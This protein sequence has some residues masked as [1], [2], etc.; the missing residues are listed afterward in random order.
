[1]TKITY[2]AI[3]LA[4][5]CTSATANINESKIKITSATKASQ[6]LQN[7][8]SNVEVI[9]AEQLKS[10]NITSLTEALD[11]VAGIDYTSYGHIGKNTSVNLRGMQSQRT[12][13]LFDGVSLQNPSSTVGASI[14]HVMISDIQR[15]EI[16][17]GAQSGIW[18]ANAAAGVINIITKDSKN[19]FNSNLDLQYGSFNTKKINLS[20]SY[21]T[22]KI[23][24]K[25]VLN[26]ITSDGFTSKAPNG[27]DILKYEDDGYENTSIDY[28]LGFN[29]NDNSKVTLSHKNIDGISQYDKTS[30]DDTNIQ[31]DFNTKLTSI[32]NKTTLNKHTIYTSYSQSKFTR[33]E[34]GTVASAGFTYNGTFYPGSPNVK[35][36]NG[37][38]DSIELKDTYKYNPTSFLNIGVSKED[39]KVNYIN[40][41]DIKNDDK[42]TSNAIFLTNNNKYDGYIAGQTI[43]TQSLRY[44]K[45]D[46]FDN[47]MTGKIGLK[48]I[49]GKIKGLTTSLNYGT[50]YNTPN[51]IQILNPWGTANHNLEAEDIK[52]IDVSINYKN[53]NL[54]YFE[55]KIDNLIDWQGT[56]YT[57]ITGVSKIKG[58]EISYKKSFNTSL[59]NLNYTKLDA[60]DEDGEDLNKQAKDTLKIS[61]D[62][63]GIKKLNININAKHIGERYNDTAKTQSTGD[64]TVIG[65][66][67]NYKIKRKI[68]VYLKIDNVTDKYYQTTYGYATSPRAYYAGIRVKF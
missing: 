6:S 40:T 4:L 9:T 17:K 44:D 53:L 68:F 66:S 65:L 13:I 54:T 56:G 57:N 67:S 18:G 31:S 46:E 29:I 20:A 25:I 7:V 64:Y 45:Y 21:K 52:T 23:D 43:F 14:Q 34:I 55:N 58:F 48:H 5:L 2:S 16:I 12:L 39:T 22:N 59:L 62:Y 36:F 61:Y 24:A 35:I 50:A 10:K 15:I 38:L 19:G 33:D 51:I 8:A 1:M 3:T 63:F 37:Q 49:H 60:K 41:S 47:K 27:E 42:F 28:K 30:A 11:L 32:K 26:K